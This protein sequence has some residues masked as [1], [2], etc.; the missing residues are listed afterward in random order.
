MQIP[1]MQNILRIEPVT[2]EEWALILILAI[3]MILV[4]EVFKLV[5][6]AK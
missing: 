5:N 2:M 3:P 4:M 6:K 1:F